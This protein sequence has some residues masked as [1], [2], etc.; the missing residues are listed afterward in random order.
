VYGRV[1]CFGGGRGLFLRNPHQ[2]R[3]QT[4]GAWHVLAGKGNL[5]FG[6][7][8]G[9]ASIFCI[10]IHHPL[11]LQN[12]LLLH[13]HFAFTSSLHLGPFIHFFGVVQFHLFS[14]SQ[15]TQQMRFE[16]K[17]ENGQP[18]KSEPKHEQWFGKERKP[19]GVVGSA[20]AGGKQGLSKKVFKNLN[21]IAETGKP[22]EF[23]VHSHGGDVTAF[24][25]NKKGGVQGPKTMVAPKEEAVEEIAELA[26]PAKKRGRPFKQETILGGAKK[27]KTAD[28]AKK[29]S[30]N[31][32]G[33]KS[34]IQDERCMLIIVV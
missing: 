2:F 19:K 34:K 24:T 20:S 29:I 22:D 6:G 32:D 13:S 7:Q 25:N 9:L 21:T 16:S 10:Q 26:P 5:N 8:I 12:H 28:P 33:G 4:K 14:I 30:A 18:Q 1:L 15:F 3:N 11:I 23:F 31:A 17:T 27:T